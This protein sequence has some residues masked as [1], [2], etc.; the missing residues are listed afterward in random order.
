MGVLKHWQKIFLVAVFL[1]VGIPNLFINWMLIDDGYDIWF[2]RE[3]SQ[4]LYNFAFI[5]AFGQLLEAGGRFRPVYWIYNWFVWLVGGNQAWVHHLA[6]I[7]IFAG[8]IILIYHFAKKITSSANAG[9]LSGIIFALTSLNYENWIRIGPQEPLVALFSLLVFYFIFTGKYK[10]AAITI[11]LS[12]FS[13]ETAVAI[14]SGLLFIF[15]FRTKMLPS[16]NRLKIKHLLFFSLATVFVLVFITSSIRS[17]YST[18]YSLKTDIVGNLLSYRSLL[19]RGLEPFLS[20]AL[21]SFTVR[22]LVAVKN[23]SIAKMRENMYLE[24]L[25]LIVAVSF[26]FLQLPWSFVLERYLLPSIAFLSVFIGSELSVLFTQ[27]LDRINKGV[28]KLVLA[29]LGFILVYFTFTA[30]MELSFRTMISVYQTD[31]VDRM[32]TYLAENA[33][34]NMTVFMN[35]E[36]GMHT[37]EYVEE[38]RLHLS[39]FKNRSDIDVKY[40]PDDFVLENTFLVSGDIGKRKFE[41]E[42]LLTKFGKPQVV[43]KKGSVPIFTTPIGLIKQTTKKI[44]R[45]VRYQEKLDW[46]GIYTNYYS[47]NSWNIYK[48]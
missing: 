47:T 27:G 19:I 13:K 15:L 16:K 25:F 14:V 18:G 35:L 21:V 28:G 10:C 42:I 37:M 39:E 9:L 31:S 2:V 3:F 22:L 45:L 33:S 24:I 34:P 11:L 40:I 43:S 12:I 32:T 26:V 48:I 7:L 6:H 36:E 4:K 30:G 41:E 38:T 29:G 23:K 17:G 5:D 46:E 20:V 44:Y 8:I 1:L